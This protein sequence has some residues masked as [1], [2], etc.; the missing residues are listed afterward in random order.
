MSVRSW[1]SLQRSNR[2][3][4]AVTTTM[5]TAL[6]RYMMQSFRSTRPPPQFFEDL[7]TLQTTLRMV[8]GASMNRGLMALFGSYETGFYQQGSDCDIS[9]YWKNLGLYHCGIPTYEERVLKRLKGFAKASSNE[10]MQGVK[11]TLAKYPVV[12]FTDPGTGVLC[13]VSV[14]NF[15][16]VE[17]TKILK[18]ICQIHPVIPI[19]VHNVKSWAK[20]REVI[21]P[22][23]SCFN[24]FTMTMMSI[25]VLQ[26]LGLVPVFAKA[27]GDCGELTDADAERALKDFKLPPIYAT[28]GADDDDKLGEAA[29]FLLRSFSQYYAGFDFGAATV[30]LIC[31]RRRRD[32]YTEEVE[33]YM[34]KLNKRKK[35][36]WLAYNKENRLD[37]G[38]D[39]AAWEKNVNGELS[40]RPGHTAVVVEDPVNYTNCG[41]RVEKLALPFLGQ[42]FQ[43]LKALCEKPGVAGSEVFLRAESPLKVNVGVGK[44]SAKVFNFHN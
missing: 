35:E 30:S 31:P 22:E 39:D 10:G 33:K 20:M 11:L 37:G 21:L 40:Q 2:R 7:A 43:R 1:D 24:S 25:M 15:G 18:R 9:L 12:Q 16:G 4:H 3:R 28:I 34:A 42:E 13:D 26:E 41:R 14:G 29:E 8:A 5:A 27:T 19:Y 38:I 36:T 23:K 17:N 44:G 6:S 32:Y